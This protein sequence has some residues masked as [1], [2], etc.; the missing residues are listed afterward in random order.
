MDGEFNILANLLAQKGKTSMSTPVTTLNYVP[1]HIYWVSNVKGGPR[2][3]NI[4]S[5][6]ELTL[7]KLKE[8][9]PPPPAHLCRTSH[10]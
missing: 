2:P 10:L 5:V 3:V 4:S 8:V 9:S 1:I 6:D 7:Y